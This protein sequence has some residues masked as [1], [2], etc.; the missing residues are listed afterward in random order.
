[1]KVSNITLK[2]D[3][4]KVTQAENDYKKLTISP[5]VRQLI[6]QIA[7]MMQNFLPIS[8]MAVKG[9]TWYTI[10]QWQQKSKMSIAEMPKM[11]PQERFRLAK[12]LFE[13]GK[14]RMAHMLVDPEGQKEL[15]E[16]VYDN[17]WKTYEQY[18]KQAS[19]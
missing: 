15:I 4:A 16:E 6:E 18:V 12:E 10:K 3:Q 2:F 13:I 17:V 14:E 11:N 1:M 7:Q 19:Q 5:E 8:A 9:N